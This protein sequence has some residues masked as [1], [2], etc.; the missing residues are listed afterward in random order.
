ML[1]IRFTPPGRKPPPAPS[2]SGWAVRERTQANK[3][4]AVSYAACRALTDLFKER[5]EIEV[6]DGLMARLHLDPADTSLD[7]AT[8]GGVGNAA[9]KAVLD[10]RHHDGSNQL[11]DYW[12]SSGTPYSDS[13]AFRTANTPERVADPDH[14]QPLRVLN[15]WG[16]YD[17]QKFVCPQWAKVTPFALTRCDQ[18]RPEMRPA[19]TT[20]PRFRAQAQQILD[21]SAHVTDRQKMIAEY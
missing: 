13:T 18:F 8:P 3:D 19:T 9:A 12:G 20:S 11:G 2:P 17:R 4:R 21:D 6:F 1:L 7:P 15:K 14:W 16:A 5:E 10:F